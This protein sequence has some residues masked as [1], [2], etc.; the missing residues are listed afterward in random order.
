[1]EGGKTHDRPAVFHPWKAFGNNIVLG[2]LD[3]EILSKYR[4][5]RMKMSMF[6]KNQPQVRIQE[7]HSDLK[8]VTELLNKESVYYL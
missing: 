3:N 4:Q 2:E 1:M 5:H 6:Q 7:R 8:M